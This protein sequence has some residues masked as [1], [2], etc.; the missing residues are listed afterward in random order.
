MSELVSGPPTAARRRV[1]LVG[2]MGS[3]KTS[4]GHALAHR[5]GWPFLD[6]DVLVER[7]AGIG[8]REI[9]DEQGEEALREAEAGALT[10]GLKVSPPVIVD[11]A[12]GVVTREADRE[13]LRGA[14]FAVWLRARIDTL[15]RRVSGTGRPWLRDDP[16]GA[17][18]RLYRGREPL[19]T[20]VAAL[21]VDVDD[22][23]PAQVADRILRGL[24][25][26]APDA[27]GG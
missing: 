26:P 5:T 27:E 8:A 3:G 25:A 13:R 20:E 22:S 10:E 23:T 9:L 2:M 6:N 21:T 12:G 18:R 4:V 11:V 24:R 17:L 15:A 16:E 7:S 19:Y 14:G 1:L